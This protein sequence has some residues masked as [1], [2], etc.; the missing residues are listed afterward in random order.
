MLIAASMAAC[1]FLFN[2]NPTKEWWALERERVAETME[3]YAYKYQW[4]L[5]PGL[6]RSVETNVWDSLQRRLTC[7][8]WLDPRDWT[9][10]WKNFRRDTLPQSCCL[11][12]PRL[13]ERDQAEPRKCTLEGAYT[14][15]CMERL[16]NLIGSW[17]SSKLANAVM[18]LILACWAFL[19]AKFG[20]P[21][22]RPSGSS[23]VPDASHCEK[24]SGL[25]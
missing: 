7:C 23:A 8:G 16:D 20:L 24:L 12:I 2:S 18:Y 1:G 13:F 19:L 3:E 21:T 25:V 14:V 17:L 15:G 4:N 10:K 11:I 9:N 6:K 22:S 5:S